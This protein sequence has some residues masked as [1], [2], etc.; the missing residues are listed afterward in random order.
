MAALETCARNL[1]LRK[2]KGRCIRI[3]TDSQASIMALENPCTTSKLVKEAKETL[4]ELARNNKVFIIWIPG[5]SGYRGNERADKLAK[6]GA[7][8]GNP[9]E[10]EV[11][12]PFQEGRNVIQ[13]ALEKRKWEAWESS[14]GYRWSKEL[15]GEYITSRAEVISKL[16]RRRARNILGILTGHCNLRCYTHKTLGHD[17]QCRWCCEEEETPSHFLCECPALMAQRRK[18]LGAEI[19]N[20]EFFKE[21]NMNYLL[22]YCKELGVI[23]NSE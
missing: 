9:S 19:L 18:W 23:D 1:V 7:D 3:C 6:E 14:Q 8:S 22:A 15:L 4:N 17:N 2:V 11:G 20:P 12:T 13:K 16:D 10:M 21:V 5:H